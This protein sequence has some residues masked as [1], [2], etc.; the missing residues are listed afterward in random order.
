MSLDCFCSIYDC[1][2]RGSF[3]GSCPAPSGAETYSLPVVHDTCGKIWF[4]TA[5]YTGQHFS[6]SASGELLGAVAFSQGPVTAPCGTYQVSAGSAPC[7]VAESCS[8][9]EDI[10]GQSCETTPWYAER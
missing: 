2:S 10:N 5:T 3:V 7:D 8:C 9:W 1:P 4:S 6:F